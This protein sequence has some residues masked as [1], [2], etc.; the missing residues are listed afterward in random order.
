MKRYD[1]QEGDGVHVAEPTRNLMLVMSGGRLALSDFDAGAV[2]LEFHWK[3]PEPYPVSRDERGFYVVVDDGT[4]DELQGIVPG[5][6]ETLIVLTCSCCGG[7]APA[8]GQWHNRDRGYGLCG[9]CATRISRRSDYDPQE[10]KR[11]YGE[12]GIHW[13]PADAEPG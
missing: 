8:Y 1:L 6:G 12:E 5:P 2:R 11:C 13:M 3:G 4:R 9:G 10:F 7:E